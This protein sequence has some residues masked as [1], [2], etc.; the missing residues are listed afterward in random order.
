MKN[1][2]GFHYSIVLFTVSRGSEMKCL[3]RSCR[4]HVQLCFNPPTDKQRRPTRFLSIIA[5]PS[6]NRFLLQQYIN[7][8][9]VF[10]KNDFTAPSGRHEAQSL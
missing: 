9:L 5:P 4:F 3:G 1:N 6:T 7:E 10:Q 2:R 8:P